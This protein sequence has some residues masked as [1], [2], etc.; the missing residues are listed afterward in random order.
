MARNWA[1]D[2]AHRLPPASLAAFV[3]WG[4]GLSVIQAGLERTAAVQVLT[5]ALAY[6]LWWCLTLWFGVAAQVDGSA[7]QFLGVSQAVT[8][9]CLG[10]TVIAAY[11][12]A[13]LAVPASW[14]SRTRGFGLGLALILAINAVRFLLFGTLLTISVAA[15]RFVHVVA[16]GALA[17]I[18]LLALWGLWAVRDVR[19]LPAYPLRLLIRVVVLIPFLL[20]AWYVVV[21]RY[22]IAVTTAVNAILV[23]IGLSIRA[24]SLVR[25]DLYRF[26]DIAFADGGIR[27][28]LASSSVTLVALLALV[29]ATPAVPRRRLTAGLAG[30]AGL[31]V[32]HVLGTTGLV[33]LA[34]T[35]PGLVPLLEVFNDFLN[36][37]MPV[38]L[39]LSFL[40]DRLV[41]APAR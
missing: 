12:A 5:S 21:D 11:V 29:L 8:P 13:L 16:W 4:L 28:E 25:L 9:N 2:G 1:G 7:L 38:V 19:L 37:A 10:L 18:V 32:L 23:G 34:R 6:L 26:I 33:L 27:L 17:P 41:A 40:G 14:S 24:V 20:L 3:G 22:L 39:W 35:A 31:F 15:F 36:L 30:V